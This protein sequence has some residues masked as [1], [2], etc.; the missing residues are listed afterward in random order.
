MVARK[1][2]NENPRE[3]RNEELTFTNKIMRKKWRNI[4]C[5]VKRE[6]IFRGKMN[7]FFDM[8]NWVR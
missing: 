2:R 1:R 4:K 7:M 3:I 8:M 5:R 6:R